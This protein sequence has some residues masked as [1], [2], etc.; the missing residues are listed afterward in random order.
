MGSSHRLNDYIRSVRGKPF[1]WGHHDCLI[2]SN[3]AFKAFHGFGYADDWVGEYMAGDDPML[4]SRLRDRFKA[5][6][7]DEAI[8]K[9]LDPIG[10]TPPRGALVA[11]K[12]IERWLI[13][14]ALGV[15]VGTK[16]AFLSRAGVIYSPLDEIDKAWMPK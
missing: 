10:Y 6:T 8:E 12:Q 9:R 11:T 16:A 4:P 1:K 14:Y 5:Q 13:G 2:F 15:C 3:D 7:F